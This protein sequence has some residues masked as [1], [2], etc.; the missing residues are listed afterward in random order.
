MLFR[1]E[2][3]VDGQRAIGERS[4]GVAQQRFRRWGSGQ[5][6]LAGADHDEQLE[7]L[8][9]GERQR[10]DVHTDADATDAP[11]CA[12]ELGLERV[13]EDDAGDRLGESVESAQSIECGLHGRVRLE[14]VGGQ[15]GDAAVPTEP[16]VQETMTKVGPVLPWE[17]GTRLAQLVAEIGDERLQ[18]QRRIGIALVV[19][20]AACAGAL[21]ERGEPVGPVCVACE[22]GFS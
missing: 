21:A 14:L 18:L 3:G 6:A 11:G 13:G 22:P 9:D 16:A 2:V 12:V 7:R 19:V 4:V 17:L 20:L 10:P 8:A 15:R 5:Q 1:G